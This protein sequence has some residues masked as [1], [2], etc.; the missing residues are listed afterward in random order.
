M[1]SKQHQQDHKQIAWL[2]LLFTTGVGQ[3][4][5]Q[6]ILNL[7][8]QPDDVYQLD[9]AHLKQLGMTQP[10]IKAFRQHSPNEPSEIVEKTLN[11][12]ELPENHL[13]TIRDD[14]YP[15]QLKNIHTPP[16]FIMVKGNLQALQL[17]QVAIVGSRYPT[18]SGEQQAFDFAEQLTH[19]GLTIT[20]GLARG[21]D[22]AAH[23]GALLARGTTIAVLGTGL[24]QIYPR[25]HQQLSEKIVEKGA[26]ISEFG[27][28][29]QAFKGNFPKRNR[30]VSGLSL[31]TLVVEATLNSGSLITAR[32]ALEQNREVFAIPGAIHN[33]QKTGCHHL[34]R[35]G[36]VLVESAEHIM[37]EL[38]YQI[39]P[40]AEKVAVPM[41]LELDPM[42]YKIV[43]AL[44]YDGIDMDELVNKTQLP[45]AQLSVALMD[46]ELSGIIT[47]ASGQYMRR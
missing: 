47:Q 2:N 33:P 35:Q 29:V 21:I 38:G 1:A 9:D 8:L 22:A 6:N 25:Q 5:V 24:N 45:V 10:A 19:L 27:L 14:C 28:D 13:L 34:I 15:Q 4:V 32:Q 40:V 17:P 39:Q 26:L 31:G 43:N 16:P 23:N 36:A 18:P 12:A 44:G 41:A 42:Q 3:K 20:S 11:W 7:E 30:I 46:L 37:A